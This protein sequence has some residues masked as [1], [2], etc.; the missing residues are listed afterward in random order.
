MKKIILLFLLPVMFSGCKEDEA[1]GERDDANELGQMENNGFDANGVSV[2]ERESEVIFTDHYSRIDTIAERILERY[3]QYYCSED[4]TVSVKWYMNETI[5]TDVVTNKKWLGD[6]QKWIITNVVRLDLA[7]ITENLQIEAIVQLPDKTVRRF[8]TIPLVT[9]KKE[10]SDAFE[11][12]FGTPRAEMG[13]YIDSDLS[14]RFSAESSFWNSS[15]NWFE[16][17]GGK[18]IRLYFWSDLASTAEKCKIPEPLIFAEPLIFYGNAIRNPQEWEIGGL[19]IK[20]YNTTFHE[21]SGVFIEYSDWSIERGCLTI[22][23]AEN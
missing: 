12:T 14:P 18:L 21:T 13:D 1:G 15:T 19:K 4:D 23:R 10:V 2:W 16:F 8:K 6:I 5:Q 3:V 11:F 7:D 20:S 9:V 17:S 22:E